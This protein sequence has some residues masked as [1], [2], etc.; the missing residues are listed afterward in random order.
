MSRSK[1]TINLRTTGLVDPY[2]SYVLPVGTLVA[3]A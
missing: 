3:G 1:R 2:L